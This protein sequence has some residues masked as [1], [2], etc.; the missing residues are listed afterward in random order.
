[1]L[2]HNQKYIIRKNKD[3]SVKLMYQS[4]PKNLRTDIPNVVGMNVEDAIF[5]IK[6]KNPHLIIEKR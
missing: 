6:N 5:L 2:N 1:M 3:N 4:L